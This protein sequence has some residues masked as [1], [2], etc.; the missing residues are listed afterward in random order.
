M[1][2]QKGPEN[3]SC[4]PEDFF[5][6]ENKHFFGICAARILKQILVQLKPWPPGPWVPPCPSRAQIYPLKAISSSSACCVLE[7]GSRVQ[8]CTPLPVGKLHFLKCNAVVILD[9]Q[10]KNLLLAGTAFGYLH[11]GH[12][13]SEQT[14]KFEL[15]K[16]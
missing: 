1:V 12:T 9:T 4:G 16:F 2:S 14:K 13:L 5:S 8:L 15:T 7:G 10:Q 11:V 6:S 3:R